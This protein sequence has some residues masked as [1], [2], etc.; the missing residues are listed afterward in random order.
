MTRDHRGCLFPHTS[1]SGI[2]Q[3]DCCL[4]PELAFSIFKSKERLLSSLVCSGMLAAAEE[5]LPQQLVKLDPLFEAEFA[6]MTTRSGEI[7]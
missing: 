4:G 7:I 2:G 6:V 1:P 3:G 5:Q